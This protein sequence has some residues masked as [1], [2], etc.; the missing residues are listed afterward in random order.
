MFGVGGGVA[1]L[2]RYDIATNTWHLVGPI[3]FPAVGTG[4]AFDPAGA[5]LYLV[6][7]WATAPGLP[8]H[9]YTVSTTTGAATLVGSTG[10][11][12]ANF[13]LTWVP[14]PPPWATGVDLSA[15]P[16]A[17]LR[18]AQEIA[19]S[20]AQPV[21]LVNTAGGLNLSSALGY[22]F[23]QG[24]VRHAR[25]E[26][27]ASLR[28][29]AGST[30]VAS[31]DPASTIGA[32][33]G[34]GSNAI[35]FSITADTTGLTATDTITIT[36]DRVLTA[37][38]DASCSF[39]LYDQPS[40]AQVG[41]AAGR[42]VS[43]SG[44]YL[45]FVP[46]WQWLADPVFTATANVEANPAF[47]AFV[48]A[49]DTTTTRAG[50]AELSY[51]LV[52]PAPRRIDGNPITLAE[53][54]ASGPSGTTAVV[55]GDF[56]A[57]ANS[58]GSFTG[59]A[60]NRVFIATN[61]TCTTLAT[62][63]SALTA[64]T[65]TFNVGATA[66]TDRNL[67]LQANGT[68]A[69]PVADYTAQLVAV[70]ASAA[71]APSSPAPLAAGRIERNG[72]ELQAPLVQMPSGWIARI[73]LTNSGGVARPFTWR[74]VPATGGSAGEA[75]T[76]TS[77]AT[78]GSGSIPANGLQVLGLNDLLGGFG[79]TPPRGSFLVTVAAPSNQIQGLYQIVNP[80]TGTIS[81]HVMVRPGSN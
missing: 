25:I 78:S 72:T 6:P 43:F 42:I 36:G 80:G 31:D 63:A 70:A 34:L 3:G 69:I 23:S 52:T 73:A 58:D 79:T 77:G 26:C 65:A 11:G 71:Y 64:T 8:G 29:A 17:P 40:Q 41:G 54:M 67:C 56:S 74:F 61:D 28:F 9:L 48:P 81:N 15:S 22:S 50:L 75:S 51:G 20:S 37:A 4:L 7:G 14:P 13:G 44:A 16:P 18:Y 27:P 59:A 57:A 33:N 12:V 53:L 32:L 38:T 68:T 62:A 66:F 45:A 5:V 55:T 30:V 24:E 35:S 10:L 76:S 47:T 39:A 19:A 60:L 46:S 21:T 49:G 1:D 2:H